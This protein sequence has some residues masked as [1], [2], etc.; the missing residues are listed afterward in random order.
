MTHRTTTTILLSLDIKLKLIK[1]LK[2]EG[3][4]MRKLKILLMF[5]H[6]NILHYIEW[7]FLNYRIVY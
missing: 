7:L 6:M 4:K 2:L 5:F 3:I 1:Q